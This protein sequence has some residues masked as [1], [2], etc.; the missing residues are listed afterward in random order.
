MVDAFYEALPSLRLDIE[1]GMYA[2]MS[3][4]LRL[5]H[6]KIAHLAAA[7]EAETFQRRHQAY[8][9]ALQAAGIP[10]PAAYQVRAPFTIAETHQAARQALELSDPPS[11]FV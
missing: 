5:G 7:V 9:G 6:T 10:V 2:A 3:H 4:L 8:R 1:A 11:A